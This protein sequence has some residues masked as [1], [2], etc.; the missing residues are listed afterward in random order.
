M[1]RARSGECQRRPRDGRTR[2]GCRPLF[3]RTAGLWGGNFDAL[4]LLVLAGRQPLYKAAEAIVVGASAAYWMVIGFWETIV[5]NLFAGLFPDWT[6]AN[7]MPKLS[8][9][10]SVDFLLLIPLALSVLLLLRL[11]RRLAGSA[12][13]PP[14]SSLGCSVVSG[15]SLP[16]KLTSSAKSDQPSSLSS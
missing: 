12:V 16:W 10:A 1:D 15:L 4:H 8:A 14:P 13:G 11:A 9:E 2:T 3:S 5:P 7:F 6:R